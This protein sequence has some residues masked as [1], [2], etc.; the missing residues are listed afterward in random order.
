MEVRRLK[1]HSLH[2]F[3]PPHKLLKLCKITRF[4]TDEYGNGIDETGAV[5]L[6]GS[7]RAVCSLEVRQVG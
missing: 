2:Y 6:K 7:M 5:V 4:Y 3:H 1:G